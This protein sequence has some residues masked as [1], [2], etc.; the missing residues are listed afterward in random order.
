ML[1]KCNSSRTGRISLLVFTSGQKDEIITGQL[2]DAP[3]GSNVNDSPPSRSGERL[4]AVTIVDAPQNEHVA[5]GLEPDGELVF[6]YTRVIKPGGLRSG[7]YFFAVRECLLDAVP[8]GP[9]AVECQLDLVLLNKNGE[10]L[11]SDEIQ[12]KAITKVFA[13]MWGCALFLWAANRLYLLKFSNRL[14]DLMACG[15]V[16]YTLLLLLDHYQYE[17]RSTHGHEDK[18]LA[19]GSAL[20]TM[21][22]SSMLF[23]ATLLACHGWCITRDQVD[24]GTRM[25][26]G[27]PLVF[28]VSSAAMEWLHRYFLAMCIICASKCSTM[29][30]SGALPAL[31]AR[32]PTPDTLLPRVPWPWLC[33]DLVVVRVCVHCGSCDG[34]PYPQGERPPAV[35][36]APAVPRDIHG[37]HPARHDPGAGGRA[38]DAPP[39]QA[40]PGVDDQDRLCWLC[41]LLGVAGDHGHLHA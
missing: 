38:Y 8:R 25:T 27:L 30:W 39:L 18:G 12:L 17:Y 24:E 19:D 34:D 10:H 22:S 9:P 29:H 35:R 5:N 14:N 2:D 28:F 6:N 11:G 26:M 21:V 3:C 31:G 40:I 1:L 41:A 20:C 15:P 33:P 13:I 16:A 23:L 37:P 36:L 7:F 4:T 32:H